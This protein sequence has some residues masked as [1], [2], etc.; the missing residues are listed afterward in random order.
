MKKFSS[1]ARWKPKVSI[2][3][4]FNRY[5]NLKIEKSIEGKSLY[6]T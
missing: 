5:L 2:S 4:G 3:L 6:E 1:F